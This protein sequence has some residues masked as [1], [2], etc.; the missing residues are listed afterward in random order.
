MKSEALRQGKRLLPMKRL[1]VFI[2]CAFFLYSANIV[3]PPLNQSLASFTN[4]HPLM[5]TG[6]YKA[7]KA[8]L[9]EKKE[10]YH[11]FLLGQ[12]HLKEKN[13]LAAMRA[14]SLSATSSSIPVTV[15]NLEDVVRYITEVAAGQP[16]F[17]FNEAI[18]QLVRMH[19]Q[20]E[21]SVNVIQLLQQI[22]APGP[23]IAEEAKF[24]EAKTL[25][26]Q[27]PFLAAPLAERLAN[28]YPENGQY[29][30]LYSRALIESD[31][32]KEANKVLEQ[33]FYKITNTTERKTAAKLYLQ[34]KEINQIL[35]EKLT[36]Q[37]HLMHAEALRLVQ[38]YG[39]SISLFKRISADKLSRKDLKFFITTYSLALAHTKRYN[40]LLQFT[41][42]MQKELPEKDLHEALDETGNYL[43]RKNQYDIVIKLFPVKPK[44]K[45]AIINILKAY[46]KKKHFNRI[47]AAEY[48]LSEYDSHSQLAA[49]TWFS[50]CLDLLIAKKVNPAQRCLEESL[51]PTQFS[52]DGGMP[53]FHLARLYEKNGDIEKAR[54]LF[55]EVYLNFPDNY[56][57]KYALQKT[58][59]VSLNRPPTYG[60]SLTNIRN[61]LSIHAASDTSLTEFFHLKS[62][63][64]VYAVHPFWTTWAAKLAN[65]AKQ[66]NKAE[67]KAAL[68]IAMGL[69][70]LGARRLSKTEPEKRYLI[71][72]YVGQ[73]I[74]NDRYKYWFL[75][76]YIKHHKFFVDVFLMSKQARKFLYPMPFYP[77][78]DKVS[79]KYGVEKE[80]IYAL[81]KQES[82]FN[83]VA[84]SYVGAKG[85][86]QVMP[87]T[88][89]WLNKRLKIS[90]LNL[91]NPEHSL[92]LGTKFYADM[93]RTHGDNFE[94]IAVAYNAGPGRL[95]R[96]KKELSSDLP[97]FVE[98]IPFKETYKY[99]KITK[100]EYDRYS[101]LLHSK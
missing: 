15:R 95:R 17:L 94:N 68:F 80:R 46:L 97:I 20:V 36:S 24:L 64:N 86:M 85:L 61:W 50:V 5:V 40:N 65:T 74:K 83:P 62:T 16:S 81:M 32:R 99:V 8:A 93:I 91:Y 35:K 53:R 90:N 34:K 72:Q 96:W 87:K 101:W 89:K 56:Y 88:A 54:E 73:Q 69:P 25:L 14:F 57:V 71:Y 22:K 58:M 7:V 55:R 41:K 26:L 1:W 63:N 45:R 78:V 28:D 51:K 23:V 39:E 92:I 100:S 33:L 47:K 4:T 67:K 48:Y 21:H 27:N 98:Q 19:S 9:P 13:K 11:Q 52:E 44:S 49:R 76:K 75:R 70:R 10:Y 79:K 3:E 18:V 43:I 38:R 66:L 42:S 37:E 59:P 60:S 6:S 30:V 84:T 31:N 12:I 29:Q 2:L 82:S 77:I